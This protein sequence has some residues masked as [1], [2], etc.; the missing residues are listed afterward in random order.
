VLNR[1]K[2]ANEINVCRQI[3]VS[4]KHYNIITWN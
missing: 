2:S 3:E 1:Q 4:N